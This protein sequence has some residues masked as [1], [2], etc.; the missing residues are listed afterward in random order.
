MST[1]G[2]LASL[3]PEELRSLEG[4][5]TPSDYQAL[6][7]H[8]VEWLNHAAPGHGHDLAAP[9]MNASGL[10]A[11]DYYRKALTDGIRNA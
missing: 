11:S 4:V 2:A 7:G 3:L 6:R 8:V 5:E 10:S 9:V 1:P